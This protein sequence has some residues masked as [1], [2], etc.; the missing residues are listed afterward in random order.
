MIGCIMYYLFKQ[1]IDHRASSKDP[2]TAMFD[3]KEVIFN[4]CDCPPDTIKKHCKEVDLNFQN[5]LSFL[6]NEAFLLAL[7]IVPFVLHILHSLNST[8]WK[9]TPPISMLNFVIGSKYAMDGHKGEEYLEGEEI[10]ME[11][12]TGSDKMKEKPDNHIQDN[13]LTSKAEWI[14]FLICLLLI[15]GTGCLPF[16]YHFLFKPAE[17]KEGTQVQMIFAS[18]PLN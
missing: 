9:I 11:P 6:P 10:E 8:L 4:K 7:M 12:I 1:S 5:L 14:S 2:L 18:S 13:Q 3:F 15:A 17:M 16:G